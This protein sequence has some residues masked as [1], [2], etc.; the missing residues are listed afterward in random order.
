MRKRSN[1]S[2]FLV[3]AAL[4]GGGFI[5]AFPFL[6]Q[7]LMSV[8]TD[9]QISSV[10]PTLIPD[11]VHLENYANVFKEIPFGNQFVTS[12]LITVIRTITQLVLCSMAG[13][14]F[15]RMHFRGRNFLFALLLII[16][17]VPGQIYLIPQYQIIQNLGLLD[18]VTGIVM[19]GL[20]SAFGTFLMKQ[21]F[22]ALPKELEES[23]R[24]DGAGHL[25]IY[26]KIMLPLVRPSLF[27]VGI[28]TVLWSWNELLWP[29]VVTS[30]PESMPL[31]V[32]IATLSGYRVSE[33]AL[34][35]AASTLAMLPIFALFFSMQKHVIEGLAY[36]GIKG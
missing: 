13:Y 14:A 3:H 4:L 23:A 25:R 6:Y 12:V 26:W 30:R 7:L 35:M 15:A 8:S 34:M 9:A 24:V 5:M 32:G 28:T 18:T 11:S 27:A 22:E 29:L 1:K 16:L 19:P 36:T 17:M 31:S 21:A 20:F 33:Y 2:L 10:P